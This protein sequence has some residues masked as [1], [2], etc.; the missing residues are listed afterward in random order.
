MSNQ[1]PQSNTS[2]SQPSVNAKIFDMRLVST[3]LNEEE[4]SPFLIA[5]IDYPEVIPTWLRD[6][7]PG[8]VPASERSFAGRKM[9][10]SMETAR[11]KVEELWKSCPSEMNSHADIEIKYREALTTAMNDCWLLHLY[12]GLEV[13]KIVEATDVP[14]DIVAAYRAEAVRRMARTRRSTADAST[15]TDFETYT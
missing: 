13:G 1:D 10:R 8:F 12:P 2:P 15:Q 14:D 11:G 4:T 5:A 9:D 3:Y 6:L 7:G